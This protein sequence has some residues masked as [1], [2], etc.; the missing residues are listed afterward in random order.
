MFKKPIYNL[1]VV[2]LIYFK[3]LRFPN[4]YFKSP[5]ILTKFVF[6]FEFYRFIKLFAQLQYQR[7]IDI[8]DEGACYNKLFHICVL[9]S[10]LPSSFLTQLYHR[11]FYLDFTVIVFMIIIFSMI[12]PLSLLSSSFSPCSFFTIFVFTS[13]LPSFV[14]SSFLT[15]LYRHRLYHRRFYHRRLT[16]IVFTIIAFTIV[17]FT[18]VVFTIVVFTIFVSTSILL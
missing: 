13:I 2:L 15:R 11:R 9:T 18:I 8:R 6:F 17:V 12:F 7:H 16:I 10:I 4:N 3:N 5:N 1:I 14:P